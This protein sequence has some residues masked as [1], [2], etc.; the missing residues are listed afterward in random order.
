[1]DVPFA[2]IVAESA[3]PQEDEVLFSMHAFFR[4][5]TIRKTN[6]NDRL[7]TVKWVL[8]KH[9]DHQQR[10]LKEATQ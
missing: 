2:H 10:L 7:F 6:S 5:Q 8:T 4:L 9:D 3:L 1:M